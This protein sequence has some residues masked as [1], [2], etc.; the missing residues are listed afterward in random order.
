MKAQSERREIGKIVLRRAIF[1][2]VPVYFVFMA[3]KIRQDPAGFSL[4]KAVLIFVV[5][6]VFGVTVSISTLLIKY[7]LRPSSER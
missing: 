3:D 1:W 4:T 7:V 5:A 2:A 6:L